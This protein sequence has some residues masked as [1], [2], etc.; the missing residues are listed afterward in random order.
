MHTDCWALNLKGI[1]TGK[2]P[3]WERM[4]RRGEYPSIR[5]GTGCVATYKNRMLVFGGV[6]DE[7]GYHHAVDS[8]FYDDLFALDMERRRW[9][10]MGLKKEGAGGGRRRRKKGAG[11][12]PTEAG[13]EATAQKGNNDDDTV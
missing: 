12:E 6:L 2:V 8:V 11:A 1:P 7:E 3:T 5:S 13:E 4:S 9:F 10:R